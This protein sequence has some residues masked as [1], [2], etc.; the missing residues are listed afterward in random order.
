[1]EGK[2]EKKGGENAFLAKE[3]SSGRESSSQ[4]EFKNDVNAVVDRRLSERLFEIKTVAYV[5]L[6]VVLALFFVVLGAAA[7]LMGFI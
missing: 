1:M 6:F 2:N 5:T 7:K 3:G 4:N